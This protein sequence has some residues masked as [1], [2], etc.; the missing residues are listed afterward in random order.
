MDF[1]P[2]NVH[3]HLEDLRCPASGEELSRAVQSND[4]PGYLVEELR[5]LGNEKFSDPD[6]VTAALARQLARRKRSTLRGFDG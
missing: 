5:N 1:N 2:I 4:A 3:K 6:E